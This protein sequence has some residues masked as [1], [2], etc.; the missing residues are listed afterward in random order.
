MI[1]NRVHVLNRGTLKGMGE[2]AKCVVKARRVILLGSS[3]SPT[4]AEISIS[5]EP[6]VLPDGVYRLCFPGF[7]GSVRREHGAWIAPN[8]RD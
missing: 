6:T 4:Y 8:P 3:T 2:K 7:T 1:P 5:D